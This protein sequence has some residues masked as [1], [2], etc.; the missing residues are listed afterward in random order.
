MCMEQGCSG[1]A[2]ATLLKPMELKSTRGQSQRRT[3]STMN[4]KDPGRQLL[5]SVKSVKNGQYPIQFNTETFILCIYY[6]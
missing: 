4:T 6:L 2:E 1:I 3:R 5:E